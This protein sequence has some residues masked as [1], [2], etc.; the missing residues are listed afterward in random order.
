MT[1]IKIIGNNAETVGYPIVWR[2]SS[3]DIAKEIVQGEFHIHLINPCDVIEDLK[4]TNKNASFLEKFDRLRCSA[5]YIKQVKR[6]LKRYCKEVHV[7]D[8]SH[9]ITKRGVI[10]IAYNTVKVIISVLAVIGLVNIFGSHNDGYDPEL[11][12]LELEINQKMFGVIRKLH[13]EL[14]EVRSELEAERVMTMLSIKF[15][16]SEK[17]IHQIF[18]SENPRFANALESL[19]PGITMGPNTPKKYWHME[20]CLIKQNGIK[21]KLIININGIRTDQ[22]YTLL[23]ADP[24]YLAVLEPKNLTGHEEICLTKYNGPQYVV[25]QEKTG[26]SAEIVFDPIE[27]HQTPFVFHS[28]TCRR[29]MKSVVNQW[30]KTKCMQSD[31]IIPEEIV[32]VKMDNEFVYYYCYTQNT[33]IMGIE[34]KCQNKIYKVKKGKN[35]TI[36]HEVIKFHKV[37]MELFTN[38]DTDLTDA[39]NSKIFRQND[40]EIALNHLEKMIEQEDQLVAKITSSYL[41]YYLIWTTAIV[42]TIAL[43]IAICYICYQ[44]KK[45]VKYR[46]KRRE[47]LESALRSERIAMT[48]V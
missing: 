7:D 29:A 17:L 46:E 48:A 39:I 44:K 36:N 13:D 1:L 32:Q 3:H 45:S 35:I 37:R 5:L 47:R 41:R 30:K 2:K 6:P 28:P 38:I 43:I 42:I 31:K 14:Y 16:E 18:D 19:F 20:S 34:E 15:S 23:R 10:S 12:K 21:T 9:E 8:E 24:F 33:T 40:V 22:D 25:Y 4:N 26:C 11:G 27:E